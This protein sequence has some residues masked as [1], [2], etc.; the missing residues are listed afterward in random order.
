MFGVARS[1]VYQALAREQTRT[2][3]DKQ[4]VA[5]PSASSRL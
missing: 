5:M 3:T 1:T 4:S 2:E